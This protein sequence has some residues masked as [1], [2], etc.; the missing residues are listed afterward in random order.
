YDAFHGADGV[1][2]IV[3][4]FVGRNLAD[5]RIMGQFAATDQVRLKRTLREQFCYILGGGCAYTGRDMPSSHAQLGSQPA[6]MAAIVE[7]LQA[8]MADERVPFAVQNRF[9]AKLAPMKRDVVTR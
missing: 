4:G 9:L 8:A 2:R 6:D 7:N 1:A 3:D 5:P